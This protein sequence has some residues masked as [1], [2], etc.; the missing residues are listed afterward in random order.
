[1]EGVSYCEHHAR[2]YFA[3]PSVAKPYIN[4][5][6]RAVRRLIKGKRSSTRSSKSSPKPET[7]TGPLGK[8]SPVDRV[9]RAYLASI[10]L[11]TMTEALADLRPARNTSSDLSKAIATL[12]YAH[13]CD[14]RIAAE[15]HIPVA[16]V[17]RFRRVRFL[18]P[19]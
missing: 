10:G 3:P 1:M 15:L 6:S 9:R 11:L 19:K 4:E 14:A 13:F 16:F 18:Q 5:S 2:R 7:I 17:E 12:Y 8:S